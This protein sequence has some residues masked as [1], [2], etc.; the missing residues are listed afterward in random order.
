MTS[1]HVVLI[2]AGL[3]AL[4]GIIFL[5]VSIGMMSSYQKKNK[6]CTAETSGTV[7]NIVRHG[8]TSGDSSVSSE[9][10]YP[11]YEFYAQ[12]KTIQKES[13]IGR[14]RPMFQIGDHIT[15]RYDPENPELFYVLEEKQDLISKIFLTVGI[16][17]IVIACII[18]FIL[19]H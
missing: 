11:V 7:I 1:S 14:D 6:I 15:V 19:K 18:F 8:T 10:Y 5:L 4:L 16:V 9:G 2:A 12:G 13:H 3:P 17:L